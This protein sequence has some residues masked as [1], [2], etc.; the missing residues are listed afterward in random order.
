MHQTNSSR[1]GAI[2]AAL[3]V[4]LAGS[5]ANGEAPAWNG[6]ATGQ[7]L[8]ARASWWNDWSS[9]D[10]GRGTTCAS[11][12]TTVPYALALPA[13]AKLPDRKT[14]PEVAQRLLAGTRTRVAK[15]DELATTAPEGTDAVT[16]IFSGSKRDASLDTESVLN[17]L[18]L[19][20]N[21]PEGKSALSDPAARAL[22]IMWSRQQANGS[23]RWLEF[24]LRPWEKDGDY[25]GAALAAVATGTAGKKYPRIRDTAI[26]EKARAL[27]NFLKSRLA[28]RP[29][30][31]NTALAL[32]AASCAPVP[33]TDDDKKAM[34]ADLFAVQG[35]DGGWSMRDLGKT[36]RDP[37]APGWKIVSAHPHDAV[38]DG[39]ATGLVVFA[40]KRAGVSSRDERLQKGLAWLS[41]HQEADGTWPTVYVNKE[42]DPAS[43]VGKFNR[44]AGAAFA[45]LALSEP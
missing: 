10:R 22:D 43:N 42:R 14:L 24:G 30:L 20:V 16:P 3:L 29:L 36:S 9:A 12:H 41:S 15:W 35:Q 44:D 5:S 19:V 32:W 17:A 8:D 26:E 7:Y 1:P 4:C 34:I 38:S 6:K 21:E 33:F 37:A 23:W 18:T 11:C 31:H 25:F 39:Y 27:G 2:A 13:L 28:D 40:L 45:L